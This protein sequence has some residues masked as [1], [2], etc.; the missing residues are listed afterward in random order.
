MGMRVGASP[1]AVCSS[2][3]RLGEYPSSRA[4]C[5]PQAVY[6]LIVLLR[7]CCSSRWWCGGGRGI[8]VRSIGFEGTGGSIVIP[9]R[10]ITF[11]KTG[12]LFGGPA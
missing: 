1:V 12:V 10:L 6:G 4:G 3:A 7:A 2:A 9:M 8:E 11:S 5:R